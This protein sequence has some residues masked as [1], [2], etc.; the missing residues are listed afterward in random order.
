MRTIS[1]IL[2]TLALVTLL[3]S[4]KKS[5]P[6]PVPPVTGTKPELVFEDIGDIFKTSA[7]AAGWILNP[8]STKITDQGICWG[9]Q[10]SPTTNDHVIHVSTVVANIGHRIDSLTP[11]T[12]YYVR[13]FAT[14]QAGTAYSVEK[15][16]RTLADTTYLKVV[17]SSIN[18]VYQTYATVGGSVADTGFSAVTSRGICWGTMETPTLSDSVIP[19]GSGA[20][21]FDC[22]IYGLT[23]NTRYYYRAWAVNAEGTA[24]GAVKSFRTDMMP[25]LFVPGS[26][27]GW[28]PADSS[29][30]IS[31]V[32]S[33][34]RYQGYFW[35]PANTQ[36]KFTPQNNWTVNYGDNGADGTLEQDGANITVT[37][38]GYY[39]LDVDMMTMTHFSLKTS[40]SV[41]GS[42][43]PGGW[44]VDSDLAWDA[45]SRTWRGL[46]ALTTGEVKFRA[47]HSWDLHYGYNGTE[48]V[49]YEGGS[50]IPVTLSGTYL[51][52]LDFSA[53]VYR[54]SLTKQ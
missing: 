42:A 35:F 1:S 15:T 40:W 50:N 30:V 23:M 9:L 7:Y 2:A 16:F 37:D 41:V 54:Y 20:G 29:T 19:C 36:Y 33:N 46:V 48:G 49:L 34:Q 26:Y 24:Y 52:V 44:D 22:N 10:P 51:V 11:G 14:N 3:Q 6:D 17:T 31:S 8:G 45:P 28:N 39:K 5:D 25:F 21:S 47:N 13:L 43:T 18:Q 53:P 38:E 12:R 32:K 27:Q 4:C